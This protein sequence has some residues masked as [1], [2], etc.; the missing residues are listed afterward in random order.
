MLLILSTLLTIILGGLAGGLVGSGFLGLVDL[1][2][3]DPKTQGAR[4]ERQAGEFEHQVTELER[5]AAELGRYL[6]SEEDVIRKVKAL[7]KQHVLYM[8]RGGSIFTRSRGL[9]ASIARALDSRGYANSYIAKA[10]TN[11]RSL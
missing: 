7:R 3:R 4:D 1:Q 2:V 5:R 8:R 9:Y 11:W 10:L 6:E